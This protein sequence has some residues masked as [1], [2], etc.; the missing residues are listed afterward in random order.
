MSRKNVSIAC[1]HV[2]GF[3]EAVVGRQV[4]TA[5]QNPVPASH[6]QFLIC[7]GRNNI[8]NRLSGRGSLGSCCSGT[9]SEEMW[10][11]VTATAYLVCG[12][13][14]CECRLG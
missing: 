14:Q 2:T 12:R 10:G 7:C 6:N 11:D 1:S 3:G 4:S 9:F 8:T 13:K 5:M